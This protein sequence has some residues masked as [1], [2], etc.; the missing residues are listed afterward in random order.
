MIKC[1][2]SEITFKDLIKKIDNKDNF[3]KK[4]KELG[5]GNTCAACIPYM[6][7]YLKENR[8]VK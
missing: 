1:H 8:N 7:D 6:L 3:L 4:A 5:V 2:C